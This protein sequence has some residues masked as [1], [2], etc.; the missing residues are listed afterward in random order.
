MK[1]KLIVLVALAILA[2]AQGATSQ[3]LSP[4][5][6]FPRSDL[7]FLLPEAILVFAWYRLD[8]TERAYPR[9]VWL[10]IGVVALALLALPYYFFRTRGA[11]KGF[12]ATFIFLGCA[13]LW[14]FLVQ[15]GE[16]ATYYGV[17]T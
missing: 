17:Q 1:L 4:G 12:V 6:A 9:S 2:F 8:S 13:V 7:A 16:Y 14:S 11:V 3:F 15:A 10:N 5:V